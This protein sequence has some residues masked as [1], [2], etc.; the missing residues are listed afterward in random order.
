MSLVWRATLA[1][2]ARLPQG[3]L[4]RGFGAVADTPIPRGMRRAVI[5]Q[6][7]RTLGID[8]SEAEQPIE[9]YGSINEF[10]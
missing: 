4:S 6:F 8:A 7:A 9:E 2:L 3:A 5:G 10:F 1:A